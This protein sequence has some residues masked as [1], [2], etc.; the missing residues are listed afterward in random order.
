[1]IQV[2]IDARSGASGTHARGHLAVQGTMP[3]VQTYRGRVTCLNVV[4]NQAT[5]GIEIVNS[6][7]PA[8]VGQGELWSVVDGGATG[9]L[10]RIAGYPLTPAPPVV[11]S[12]L[13]FNVFVLSGDYR[14]NDATV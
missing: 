2:R 7:D 11:C 3:Y 8:M 6:T 13:S 12:L 10:D 1:V 14:V 5:V 9:E 4:G